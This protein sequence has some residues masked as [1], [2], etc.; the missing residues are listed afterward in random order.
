MS[1]ANWTTRVLVDNAQG[2]NDTKKAASAKL[3]LSPSQI[4]L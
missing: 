1:L 4:A 2:G 3:V